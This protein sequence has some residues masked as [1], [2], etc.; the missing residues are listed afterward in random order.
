MS[1]LQTELRRRNDLFSNALLLTR[2]TGLRI[3]ETVDLAADCLRHLLGDDWALHV[4]ASCTTN[5]GRLWIQRLARWWRLSFLRT[6]PG[7]EGVPAPPEFLLPRPKGR[8]VL[9]N[10][11]RAALCQ[12]AAQADIAAHIVPH[13]LRHYAASRTMPRGCASDAIHGH[14]NCGDAA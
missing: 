3:G 13:Q 4:L 8:T 12:A 5:V 14:L 6:P 9:A 7:P 1:G 11:L 10:D 2:L